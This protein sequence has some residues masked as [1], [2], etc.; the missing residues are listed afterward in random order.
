MT[1]ASADNATNKNIIKQHTKERTKMK[2]L[3][4]LILLTMISGSIYAQG[5]NFEQNLSWLQIKEKAKAENKFIFMDCNATWCGPCRF[6]AD[7][8]FTQ[9]K[10]GDFMNDKFISVKI[11]LDTTKNDDEQTKRWYKDAAE[12]SKANKVTALPAYLFF[13]PYGKV[14]HKDIG[15]KG[16]KGFLAIAMA[17][18]DPDKQYYMLLDRFNTGNLKPE[19]M[20]G[21][22]NVAKDFGDNQIALE[23]ADK[24]RHDYLDKLNDESFLIKP[25]LQFIND[26]SKMLSSTDRVFKLYEK[27]PERIDSIMNYYG[28]SKL[29]IDYII[30]KEEVA[31]AI[32]LAKQNKTSPNW[33]KIANT[34]VKKYNPTYAKRIVTSSK[35]SWYK[36]KKDWTNYTMFLVQK[37]EGTELEKLPYSVTSFFYLNNS[38]WDIFQYSNNKGELEKAISWVDIAIPMDVKNPAGMLDTKANLLYKLGRNEE[39]IT[40]ELKAFTLDSGF[41]ETLEKMRAGI[42]TWSTDKL[43]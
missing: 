9:K 21:L 1:A 15:A 30:T 19:E 42:Q 39:A 33:Q 25:N 26:H 40:L 10:V 29:K 43:Y 23:I 6:M 5:I 31:P 27:Y 37:M 36:Y 16:A 4:L 7:S 14:V 34:I 12:I 22:A 11:Q 2:K 28:Y 8:V 13:T 35:V 38:A 20:P 3:K 32:N 41:K 24:Y 17:A 18:M